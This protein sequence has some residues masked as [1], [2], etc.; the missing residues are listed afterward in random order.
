MGLSAAIRGIVGRCG[1]KRKEYWFQITD[2][3]GGQYA[4]KVQS[5]F[6]P[7]R[8]YPQEEFDIWHPADCIGEVGAAI[9]LVMAGVLRICL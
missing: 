2:I 9:G 6:Q 3:S 8:P 1:E 7:H 5:R 4:F